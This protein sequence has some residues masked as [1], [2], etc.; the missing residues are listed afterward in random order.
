[1]T[2]G[3]WYVGDTPT[4][5]LVI[6]VQRD[7]DPVQL[8]GYAS[9]QVLLYGPD[10]EA[11]NWNSIPTIDVTLD[12]VNVPAPT[13]SPFA[14]AGIYNLYLRLTASGGGSETFFATD[15]RVLALGAANGWATTS[16]VRSITGETVTEDELA[17]AQGVIELYAGRTFAGSKDNES[18][19]VKDVVW[20]Q[21]AVAYQAVWQRQ[22]PGYKTR[23]AIKEVN[24]DGA[25]IIY[26]GSSEPNNTA[27][28]ML[29]PLAQRSLKN[30]SWMRSRT[31]KVKAP[32]WDGDHPSYGDYKRNDDH[33]GWRPM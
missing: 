24:Q 23:H 22:Q 2:L 26:A 4:T 30:V 10:G 11:V 25:Q 31:I 21:K 13:G 8:D 7:G 29:A 15:V 28:I 6:K 1:M 3:P 17:D 33:P 27:L 12:V 14:K 20:L 32:S 16:N 9:A 5:N 18:I 19:R